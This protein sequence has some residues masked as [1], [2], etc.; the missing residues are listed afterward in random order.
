MIRSLQGSQLPTAISSQLI[1][2]QPQIGSLVF[3]PQ[4]ILVKCLNFL[5][6]AC[7]ALRQDQ[8]IRKFV[9]DQY[10]ATSTQLRL[11]TGLCDREG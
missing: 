11:K 1:Q 9:T 6:V 10:K 3:G 5:V 8:G 2:T 7:F 4:Q